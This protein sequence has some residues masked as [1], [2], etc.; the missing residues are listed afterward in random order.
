[1]ENHELFERMILLKKVLSR[2]NRSMGMG[3]SLG[4]TDLIIL[5]IIAENNK[6]SPSKL[7][8][9]TG[10]SKSL[11]TM[12]LTNLEELNLIKR[13]RGKD[14]RKIEIEM[15]K[16][17]M[18]KYEKI[19]NRFDKNFDKMFSKLNEEEK[20]TLISCIDKV[21]KIIEKI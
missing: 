12:S 20:K 19:K 17:G 11:I 15:T 9:I 21:I 14:R 13:K 5:M 18:E 10:F 2:I 6:I 16:K 1:M 4:R 3:R 8:N 7:S